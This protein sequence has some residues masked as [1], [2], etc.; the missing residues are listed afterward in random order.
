MSVRIIR[1]ESRE[2]LKEFL[3]SSDP[4]AMLAKEEG[5]PFGETCDHCGNEYA[6][7]ITSGPVGHYFCP[8]CFNK[9]KMCLENE[10]LSSVT[11]VK[12]LYPPP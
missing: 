10:P 3:E 5:Y 4:I 7:I 2:K 9:L 8:E 11:P 12:S 1:P 6:I